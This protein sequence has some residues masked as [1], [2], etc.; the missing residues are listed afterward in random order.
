ML[1]ERKIQ[2]SLWAE[3]LSYMNMIHNYVSTASNPHGKSP[4]EMWTNRKPDL[5]HFREFGCKVWVLEEICGSKLGPKS[6]EY[7]FTGFHQG[8]LSVRYYKFR[9]NKILLSRNYTFDT[10]TNGTVKENSDIWDDLKKCT[11]NEE[12][13]TKENTIESKDHDLLETS[14]QISRRLSKDLADPIPLPTRTGLR[15]RK[16][17]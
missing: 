9:T 11:R 13:S 8:S 10:N 16:K 3:A 15:T 7:L 5:S 6:Q 14:D 2:R 1:I 4:Y 12:S 17:Y